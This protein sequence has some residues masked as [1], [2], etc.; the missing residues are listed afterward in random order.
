MRVLGIDPGMTP[1]LCLRDT[2]TGECTAQRVPMADTRLDEVGLR[3]AIVALRPDRACIELVGVMPGQGSSSS[4]KFMV[5][6]GLARGICRGLGLAYSLV[7]P[8]V[9]KRVV[10][11]GCDMGPDLPKTGTTSPAD[12]KRVVAARKDAQKAAAVAYVQARYPAVQL[13]LP[14]CRVPDHNLAEAVCIADYGVHA[15]G[16]KP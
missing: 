10:L 9:W 12:R 5:A 3:A 1:A 16:T 11:A 13:V 7:T 2:V 6:W 4:G 15:I 14:R 8:Q